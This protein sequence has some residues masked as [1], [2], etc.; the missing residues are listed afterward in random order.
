MSL[1]AGSR[2]CLESHIPLF[3]APDWSRGV[4]VSF[5]FRILYLN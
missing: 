5:G 1:K 2:L 4:S 3:L